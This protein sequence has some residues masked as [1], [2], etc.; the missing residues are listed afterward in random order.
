SVYNSFCATH[1]T[2]FVYQVQLPWF[3]LGPDREVCEG[4]TL[5]L[6]AGIDGLWSS[7]AYGSSIQALQEGTYSFSIEEEGCISFDEVY[8]DVIELPEYTFIS[9]QY[10][11]MGELH[12]LEPIGAYGAVFEW[13]NGEFGETL[14]IDA[15]GN[16][17]VIVSNECGTTAAQ[18]EVIYQDCEGLVFIPNCFTPDGDGI[19]DVWSVSGADIL[20]MDLKIFNRWGEVIF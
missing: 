6:N 15:P 14:T 16:Y 11:C 18:V 8:I 4:D 3:D 9:P 10:A 1:D 12:T 5:T 7:G 20:G 13:E 17:Y 19:N 2:F